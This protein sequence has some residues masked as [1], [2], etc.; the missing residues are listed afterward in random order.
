M[1]ADT[2][3]RIGC[4]RLLF[5]SFNVP[6][7]TAQDAQPLFDSQSHSLSWY[8]LAYSVIVLMLALN[9]FTTI[10]LDSYTQVSN[11]KWRPWKERNRES[12]AG[13]ANALYPNL[14]PPFAEISV[15]DSDKALG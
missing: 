2:S 3:R 7:D 6:F 11:L 9:F 10:V 12:I 8:L 13:W 15:Y 4:S 5:F 1:F 14:D